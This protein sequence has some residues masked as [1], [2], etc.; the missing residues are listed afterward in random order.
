MYR[1]ENEARGLILPALFFANT[2]GRV[3]WK[4]KFPPL[5][6]KRELGSLL[7]KPW[8]VSKN[9]SDKR[10]S[11]QLKP[12]RFPMPIVSARRSCEFT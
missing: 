6:Q 1:D 3:K 5:V 9:G 4:E 12:D 2:R 7:R 8:D 10:G 11:Q